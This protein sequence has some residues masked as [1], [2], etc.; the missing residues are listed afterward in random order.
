MVETLSIETAKISI[1]N[2]KQFKEIEPIKIADE[3]LD[4]YNQAREFLTEKFTPLAEQIA[5]GQSIL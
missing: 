5:N 1:I 4:R 3:L 2:D